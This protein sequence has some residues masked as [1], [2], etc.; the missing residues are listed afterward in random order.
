[1]GA[2]NAWLNML[3]WKQCPERKSLSELEGRP[4]YIGL[5][6]ASKIDIAGN[7]LVF[8]P[9]EGDPPLAC[10]R[11]VLLARSSSDRGTGQQHKP[12]PRVSTPWD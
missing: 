2:K 7:L 11:Q 10:S 9:I 5:D 3:R 4:C 12:L 8:P 1:V 6:L